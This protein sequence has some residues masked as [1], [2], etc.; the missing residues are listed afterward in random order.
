[1]PRC[2]VRATVVGRGAAL[3]QPEQT[4]IADVVVGVDE[5]DHAAGAGAE[6]PRG[7]GLL[8]FGL[9]NDDEDEDED[10]RSRGE[11]G[12][13][14]EV[15]MQLERDPVRAY[16]REIGRV[17]LLTAAQEIALAKRVERG[18]LPA[19]QALIEANLRLVVSIAKRYTG[20]G[21]LLLDLIQEGNL[22]LMRAVEKFD[23]RRGC[24]LST[25]ATWW[26]R[27]AIVRGITDQ[28]RTIRVPA[29][30]I[31]TINRL[32]GVQ[33]QLAQEL[34]RDPR[35]DEIARRMEL[36]PAR[37]AEIVRFAERP[38]SLE[39]PLGAA[40]EASIGD[41][42]A[43]DERRRPQASL[44][45]ALQVA[46]LRRMVA[47]LPERERAVLELR[48]G[49]AGREPMTLDEIGLEFGVTRERIR[50]VESR[51][52]RRLQRLVSGDR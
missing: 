4:R 31:E 50:Q 34:E 28:A 45:A 15:P 37:V 42:I 21:M 36:T 40:G 22:G 27:Q 7:V 29:H 41:V 25:Y 8:E 2:A 49:L 18:D 43:D 9:P 17:P 48:Y 35:T 33:R 52:L 12:S 10:G 6:C 26:I 3:S 32:V 5:A 24:R 23:W 14:A 39:T 16:L 19:K 30:M 38:V 1:M 44:D 46:D 47:S 11:R 51:A 13:A 20:R